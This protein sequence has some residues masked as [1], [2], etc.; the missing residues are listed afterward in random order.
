MG[1]SPVNIKDLLLLLQ[2]VIVLGGG[3]YFAGRLGAKID[4]LSETIDRLR[5]ALTDHSSQLRDHDQR[6]SKVEQAAEDNCPVVR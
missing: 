1:D 3:F 4:H 6:I 5:A 2:A